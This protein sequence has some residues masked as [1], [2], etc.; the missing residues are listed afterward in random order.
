MMMQNAIFTLRLSFERG[1]QNA[2]K[3]KGEGETPRHPS[4][5]KTICTIMYGMFIYGIIIDAL[6]L[7]D[8]RWC[9]F[10]FVNRTV[11]LLR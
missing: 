7:R 2:D 6:Y 9:V 5:A 1:T 10:I 11:T 4:R 3:R 8:K